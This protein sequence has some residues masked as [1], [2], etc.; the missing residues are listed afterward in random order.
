MIRHKHKG[1]THTRTHGLD[2]FRRSPPLLPDRSLL[3]LRLLDL[4]LL[5]LLLL[6]ASLPAAF[7]SS[8]AAV[9]RG[10]PCG[11]LSK[12]W[13]GFGGGV[14]SA[15]GFELFCDQKQATQKH[16]PTTPHNQRLHRLIKS[17]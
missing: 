14:L 3:L 9:K 12:F 8:N 16:Q 7:D 1:S 11:L 15:F 2:L 10:S 4:S 13:G 17:I 5:L 6:A